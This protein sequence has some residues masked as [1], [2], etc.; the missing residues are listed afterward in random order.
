M[1][2][3]PG[4]PTRRVPLINLQ[5]EQPMVLAEEDPG[6]TTA[7]TYECFETQAKPNGKAQLV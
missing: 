1:P 6:I 5:V 3:I 7:F 4:L 2:S